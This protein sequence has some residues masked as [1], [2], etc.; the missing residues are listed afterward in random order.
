MLHP[1]FFFSLFLDTTTTTT[2][3]ARLRRPRCL[4]DGETT[5]AN[6]RYTNDTTTTITMTC[7]HF[8]GGDDRRTDGHHS[9]TCAASS[10]F[11]PPL[12]P[13]HSEILLHF[14]SPPFRQCFPLDIYAFKKPRPFPPPVRNYPV[15]RA[16]E[17]LFRSGFISSLFHF[18]FFLLA[19]IFLT[20]STKLNKN[21]FFFFSFPLFPV[22][23]LPLALL[24]SSSCFLYASID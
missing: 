1:F 17:T 16:G 18:S 8:W 15:D 11:P 2:T 24:S 20:T 7:V 21:S 9:L 14:F 19:H 3:K 22:F 6:R 23:C 4:D 12:R 5:T 13:N 10:Q